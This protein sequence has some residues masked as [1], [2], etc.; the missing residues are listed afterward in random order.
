[1]KQIVILVNYVLMAMRPPDIV[2]V[3]ASACLP[4]GNCGGYG[5]RAVFARPSVTIRDAIIGRA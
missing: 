2:S 1:M 5:N 3:M 4:A